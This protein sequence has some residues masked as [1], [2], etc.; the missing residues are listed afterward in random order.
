[1]TAESAGPDLRHS[2]DAIM[3]RTTAFILSMALGLCGCSTHAERLREVRADFYGG[4]LDDADQALRRLE[5]RRERD[6]DVAR[7]DRAVLELIQGHSESSEQLLRQVRD[8]FDYLEQSN[9]SEIALA[10]LTDDQRLAY[11]GEDYEK[12]L[13]RSFLAL[14]SLMHGGDDAGAYALQVADKQQQIMDAGRDES[15]ENP[16]QRYKRLALGAYIHGVLREATHTS[17]DDARRS[18]EKVVKWQPEFSAGRTDLERAAHGR[19]SETG[20]GVLYVF[21]LVGRGPY[22]EERSEIAS[23]AALLVADRIVSHN[24]SHTLPPTLAPIKVARVIRPPNRISS[25]RVDVDGRPAGT[26]ETIADIG[27]FAVEQYDAIFPTIVGRAIARRVLKKGIVYASKEIIQGADH[28][29][30]NLAID[31][32]GVVWEATES[33]DTRCWGLLPDRVQVRR[34]EL[35]TGE[36]RLSLRAVEREVAGPTYTQDVRIADGRNTYVLAYFPTSQLIG[37]IITNEPTR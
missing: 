36:H 2:C 18:Y 7:L 1:M 8:R 9:V 13:V 27:E 4:D 3:L 5:E 37:S 22:K 29:A 26:T 14:C 12:L 16:K 23:S 6:A 31:A 19:H 34:V 33:A 28:P 10:S 21:A 11:A 25:I 30:A 35:A 15:G 32:A 24:A 20:H 17:Y